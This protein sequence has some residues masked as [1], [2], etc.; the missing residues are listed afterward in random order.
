MYKGIKTINF[1]FQYICTLCGNLIILET[2]PNDFMAN[3]SPNSNSAL[4]EE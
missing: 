1:D 4:L 2:E 3:I